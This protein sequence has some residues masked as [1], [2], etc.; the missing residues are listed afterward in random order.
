[1][2]KNAPCKINIFL[3]IIGKK[4]GYHLLNSRFICH[5]SLH[6]EISFEPKTQTCEF[7]LNGDFDCITEKNI[8]F[9]AYQVLQQA[10]FK[11]EL[12]SFFASHGVFVKKHIPSCAGLGGGSS[13]AASFILLCNEVLN[14]KLSKD[15]L[16]KIGAKVGADVP[17]FIYEYKS[18]NV[19]GIGEIVKEFEDDIPKLELKLTDIIC[20]TSK[21]F[22]E[23]SKD[24]NP[25]NK[26]DFAHLN[27]CS[28]KMLLST[29]KPLVL[30]DLYQSSI[31]LNENLRQF[32]DKGYF[33]S[34]SGSSMFRIKH[35]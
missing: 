24:F 18:A 2:K 8:I 29:F 14:L 30:N 31:A 12:K 28:S 26:L 17:F 20:P 3:K 23:F 34:G 1:M 4:D 25:V 9:K 19:S 6:D 5:E 33:M 21:V 10:G 27:Q 13:D 15:K 7:E 16:A 22:A 35:G 11:R 32:L